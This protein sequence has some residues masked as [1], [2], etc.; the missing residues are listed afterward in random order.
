MLSPSD[1]I[2]RQDGGG[3]TL[4]D[5]DRGWA[6]RRPVHDTR[7]SL[8]LRNAFK[9]LIGAGVLGILV[10]GGW[11][12]ARP[13]V[14][15]IPFVASILGQDEGKD[16][17]AKETATKETATKSDGDKAAVPKNPNIVEASHDVRQQLGIEYAKAITREIVKP[18]S[19]PGI[20]AFDERRVTRLKPRA[21]GRVLSIAVQ[22][23]DLVAAGQVLATIDAGDVLDAQNGLAGAKAALGEAKAAKAAAEV[24]L[25][26]ASAL[27]K[28]G[29]VAKAELEKRQVELAKE[30]AAVQSAQSRVDTFSAQYAR[31]APARGNVP[32]VSEIAAPFK[33]VVVSS[34]ITL[35]E[36]IDTTHD[37]FTVAD[38]SRVL[39]LA[40]LFGFDITVVERGDKAMIKAP[41]A[42]KQTEFDAKVISVNA[43]L[44]PTTNAAPARL[45]VANPDN[46]LRANMFVSVDIDAD[47][48]RREVTIPAA[49]V[50]QHDGKSVAFV[51][52]SD[53]RF[54]KR[55]LDLGLQRPDW[56]E[57]KKG[58]SLGETV[59]TEGSFGL[60]ALLVR[61]LL[62]AAN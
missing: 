29:G 28:I 2:N 13:M 44:D 4:Y 16:A 61:Q 57:V 22:P 49:A 25:K 36:V 47:L 51:Q 58:V 5:E 8:T 43:A 62:E 19:V 60:K 24:A 54:E 14:A 11:V 20:V 45:E 17:S 23:G 18:V 32:G 26:R 21:K 6:R 27:L 9:A 39:V 12:F 40:S 41:L 15:N 33:G 37:A 56:V 1:P 31:L 10:F 48:G 38:P 55:D 35:G 30:E 34:N 46:A 7:K 52:V 50:Q 3:L 53:N 59:V 42:T